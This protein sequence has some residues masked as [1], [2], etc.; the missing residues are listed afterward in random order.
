[1]EQ[2]TKA[3]IEQ[4]LNTAKDPKNYI[5]VSEGG[6]DKYLLVSEDGRRIASIQ[7]NANGNIVTVPF[8]V[9]NLIREHGLESLYDTLVNLPIKL[10]YDQEN[11]LIAQTIMKVLSTPLK[12]GEISDVYRMRD[13]DLDGVKHIDCVVTGTKSEDLLTGEVVYQNG[14]LSFGYH[15]P[16]ME[17]DSITYEKIVK[18]FSDILM[19]ATP[20]ITLH[21]SS[22][23]TAFYPISNNLF[24]NYARLIEYTWG[25]EPV[26]Y[27]I[28]PK[29]RLY[30]EFT[31]LSHI[32]S[33]IKYHLTLI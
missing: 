30:D 29:K 8:H 28:N 25:K 33:E 2:Y 17:F 11:R 21:L 19:M 26:V 24:V 5:R 7:Y 31:R 23:K 9:D 15:L 3:Q 27:P 4:I 10:Q 13:V 16:Y 20:N 32:S 1:M 14:W 6:L 18:L 22:D 12:A